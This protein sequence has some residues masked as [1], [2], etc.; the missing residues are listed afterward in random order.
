MGI[1]EKKKSKQDKKRQA[2]IESNNKMLARIST[3]IKKNNDSIK[4]I[5]SILKGK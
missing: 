4:R 2:D 1:F 5:N 3:G